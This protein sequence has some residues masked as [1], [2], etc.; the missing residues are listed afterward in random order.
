MSKLINTVPQSW[1]EVYSLYEQDFK[2]KNLK[3]KNQGLALLRTAFFRYTLPKYNLPFPKGKKLTLVELNAAWQLMKQIPTHELKN[4]LSYQDQVFSA[5]KCKLSIG[6]TYR[7]HLT[8]LILWS[9]QQSWWNWAVIVSEKDREKRCPKM[10]NTRSFSK[11]KPRVTKRLI[12]RGCPN[13]QYTLKPEE[14]SPDLQ[15]EFD[16]FLKFQTALVGNRNRQDQALRPVSAMAHVTAAKRQLGWLHRYQGIPL[17]ELNLKKL[18]AYSG[19]TP[20]GKPDEAEIK[21]VVELVDSHL[22]WLREARGVSPNTELKAVECLVAVAKFLYHKASKQRSRHL[23]G[24]KQVGYKDIPIIEELRLLESEI[25]VRVHQSPR[26]SDESKKWLDWPVFLAC[27]RR[28]VEECGERS[29]CGKKRPLKAIAQSYQMAV[30]FMLLSVFPD[31]GRTLTELELGRT[32]FKRDDKWFVEH[33][34]GDFKTGDSFCKNGQKRVIE[35]PESLYPF[36]TE[37]LEKWRPIFNPKH[38]YFFTKANGHPLS[39]SALSNYFRSRSYRLT[40]QVFTLHMVRD[41]IVTHLK[42]SGAQDIVLAALA[43]LMAH[44]QK[45]QAQI[46]DRR[47]PSQKVAPALQALQSLSAG[48]LPEPI[49]EPLVVVSFENDA[50]T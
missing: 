45:T 50:E 16:L 15:Q 41:S 23:V 49:V 37:W 44:S 4:A 1:A 10:R 25:M 36:F 27:G 9:Q 6:R 2:A 38:G 31:R 24:G 22:E 34:A 7:M 21:A 35:L 39:T 42:L 13:F 12:N 19:L 46:Y 18:V 3:A 17:D 32:L 33:N 48:I 40:G 29:A 26:C 5:L 30:I 28:L 20:E 47:T 43:E 8:K 11:D 14:I